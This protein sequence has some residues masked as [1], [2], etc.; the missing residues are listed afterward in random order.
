MPVVT[1]NNLI[2]M[3]ASSGLY[4]A[5]KTTENKQALTSPLPTSQTQVTNPI[6]NPIANSTSTNTLG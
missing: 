2:L 4:A 5:L 6:I 3:G 1:T